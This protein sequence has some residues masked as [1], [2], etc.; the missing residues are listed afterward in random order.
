[1]S[2]TSRRTHFRPFKVGVAALAEGRGTQACSPPGSLY[3]CSP[4]NFRFLDAG[5]GSGAAG[6]V[7]NAMY[8]N[9]ALRALYMADLTRWANLMVPILDRFYNEI[10]SLTAGATGAPHMPSKFIAG[11]LAV[12]KILG[13]A[14]YKTLFQRN[15][16]MLAASAQSNTPSGWIGSDISHARISTA[17]LHLSFREQLRGTLPVIVTPAILKGVG[18][19]FEAARFRPYPECFTGNVVG[20]HGTL[21][22]F[23]TT[24]AGN[25]AASYSLQGVA[26]GNHPWGCIAETIGGLTMGHATALSSAD[27]R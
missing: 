27:A 12:G 22:R 8:E 17:V 10:F 19:A 11:Y 5:H 14:R 15:A 24:F 1:M 4:G 9:P 20:H 7:M 18:D 16:Q 3:Q 25:V 23:S 21:V 13:V 6:F 2:H 26:P